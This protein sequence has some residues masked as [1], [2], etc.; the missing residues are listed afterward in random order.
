MLE[1]QFK[2]IDR[3]R[4]A[5]GTKIL[6]AMQKNKLEY[7][8]FAGSSGY[9]YDDSGREIIEKIYADVFGAEDA[10]VRPQLMSGTHALTVS[11]FGNLRP[12]DTL[13]SVVGKPYDTL[14]SVIGI[15]EAS[16]SLAEF[17]VNYHQVDLLPTNE[18]D[19]AGI[20]NAITSSTKMVTIQ[21]SK[22]Y[23]TRPTLSVAQIAKIIS[24]VKAVRADI[25]CL[26]DNCYGEFVEEIEPSEVGADL[27]VGSLIKNPGGGLCESGGYIVGKRKYVEAA[28]MR[29]TAPGL[30]KEVGA[31]LGTNKNVLQGLFLAPEVVANA[32]KGAVYAAYKFE[33]LGFNAIPKWNEKRSDIVQAIEMNTAENVIAFCEGIQ[34][35]APVDSFVKPIPWEMPGYDVPVVMAAGAFVQ[36]SS[37][38][39]SADAPIKPPFTVFF[40]GGLT[41]YHAQIGI[42]TALQIMKDKGLIA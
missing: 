19:F 7:S 28:A 39:L 31:T 16:G 35:A 17:G 41:Q 23:S 6:A 32:L 4:F 42:D 10:L 9:G 15:R 13:L 30:G 20:T 25:I 37:I 26:V 24:T 40:Q 11:F 22:G 29:L 36:G 21:R 14:L 1:E 34:K 38:E 12:G 5:V 2:E 33:Q 27:V 8:H 3:I 18:I